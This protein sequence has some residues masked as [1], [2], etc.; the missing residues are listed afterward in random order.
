MSSN[1]YMTS[2]V[3]EITC[4]W[5]V[6]KNKLVVRRIMYLWYVDKNMLVVCSAI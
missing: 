5:Y 3:W 4:L 2:C 6:D 1:S